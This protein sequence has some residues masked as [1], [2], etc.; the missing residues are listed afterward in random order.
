MAIP[1][2]QHK[3][4][5][6]AK[7]RIG[8][9]KTSAKGNQYPAALDYFACDDPEFIRVCGDK[10][11][12]LTIQLPFAEPEANF[13][14]GLE[15]WAGQMLVCYSKGET[16]GGRPVAWRRQTMKKG[17]KEVNLLDGF[18]LVTD[19][20]IG[21]D[22]S[23]VHCL[24]RQCPVLQQKECKPMARLQF[25]IPGIDPTGG[26]FQVDTKSWNTIER[27]E[28]L[29]STLGDPRGRPLTLVVEMWGK[30]RDRFPVL[31]LEVPN[32][33]VNTPADVTLADALIELR[34]VYETAVENPEQN[35][36]GPLKMAIAAT[37]DIARPGWR[38]SEPFIAAMKERFEEN[39]VVQCAADFLGRYEA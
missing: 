22:R 10:P 19:R 2:L 18:D 17:G 26:V 5:V 14:T 15:Q 33:E 12:R 13:S 3:H 8:E 30:G 37:L 21:Q 20:V 32:M 6:R 34:K 36:V 11:Q 35:L 27:I 4:E 25:F 23:G 31:S 16:Y 9:K 1:G 29:L 28:G 7:V 24:S 39:G 38:E